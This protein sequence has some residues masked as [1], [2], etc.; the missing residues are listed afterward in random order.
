[1][2]ELSIRT[3]EVVIPIDHLSLKGKL[4]V[5]DRATRIIIFCSG[6]LKDPSENK[7]LSERF[8]KEGYAT[9]LFNLLTPEEEKED[10]GSGMIKEKLEDHDEGSSRVGAGPT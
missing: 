2:N 4:F 9:L 8:T 1:M 6:N 10:H 3:Q 7:L 5:P